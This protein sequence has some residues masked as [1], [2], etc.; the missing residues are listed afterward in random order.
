MFRGTQEPTIPKVWIPFDELAKVV[1]KDERGYYGNGEAYISEPLEGTKKGCV[2]LENVPVSWI[3]YVSGG[4][5]KTV[6]IRRPCSK[7][8]VEEK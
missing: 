5:S 4:R 3:S 2:V 8:T 1:K 6:N 7:V